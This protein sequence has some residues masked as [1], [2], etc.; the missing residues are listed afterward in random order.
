MSY[1]IICDAR[2]GYDLGISHLAL[3]DRRRCKKS[4]WTSDDWTKVMVFPS[5]HQA[6]T[7]LRGY[8][9]NNPQVV[10]RKEAIDILNE[11]ANEINHHDAMIS[12]EMGWDAH[13]DW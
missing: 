5:K 6:E 11:Q 2:S 13:K 9:F 8:R 10:S 4:F 3:V 7:A 12:C 1:C